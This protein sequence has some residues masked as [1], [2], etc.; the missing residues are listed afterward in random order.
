MSAV[1]LD[2]LT[3]EGEL[4]SS[5]LGVRLPPDSAYADDVIVFVSDQV[6]VGCQG[7]EQMGPQGAGTVSGLLEAVLQGK[8]R[9]KLGCLHLSA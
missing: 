8:R 1:S 5:R 6:D 9:R 7:R 4:S 2:S 3:M